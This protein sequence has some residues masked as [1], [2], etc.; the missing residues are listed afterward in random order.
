VAAA[1]AACL[2]YLGRNKECRQQASQEIRSTLGRV[3]FIVP[4]PL[5]ER[6]VYTRA[7]LDEAMRMSPP[8]PGVFFREC[9]QDC[10]IDFV[11]LSAGTQVAVGINALHHNSEYF[12]DPSTYK[13]E[14]FLKGGAREAFM[15]FLKGYRACPAQKLAYPMMLVPLAHLLW[16][17][18]FKPVTNLGG[19]ADPASRGDSP[20]GEGVFQVV[21][22]LLL[23]FKVLFWPSR[24]AED[25]MIA[26]DTVPHK[27]VVEALHEHRYRVF[28]VDTWVNAHKLASSIRGCR[29]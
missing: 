27:S 2:F 3:E 17:F 9:T 14:R 23:V 6:C 8:A 13:P 16:H 1:I 4:G 26:R 21:I 20:C 28:L 22:A 24:S 18:D 12:A 29:E 7:C 10:V 19:G 15:P 25:D 5:L 11:R